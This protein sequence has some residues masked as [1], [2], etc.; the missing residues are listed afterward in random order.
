[1]RNTR[2]NARRTLVALA[3]AVVTVTGGAA[4]YADLTSSHGSA[5]S[6]LNRMEHEAY[7]QMAQ[8]RQEQAAALNPN[9]HLAH[10]DVDEYAPVS[11]VMH[12]DRCSAELARAWN[13][14]GHYSDGYERY[15]LH[16]PPCST[17]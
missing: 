4:A 8:I 13:R 7:R 14:L 12:P 11:P 3:V 17:R 9:E 5:T 10:R 1:M 6:G 16:Q 15:L 2:N